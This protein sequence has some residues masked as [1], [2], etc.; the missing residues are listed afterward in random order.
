M[1]VDTFKHEIT[2]AVKAYDRYVICIDKVLAGFSYTIQETAGPAGYKLD[3]ST[4]SVSGTVGSCASR[5]TG[6]TPAK[7]PTTVTPDALFDNIPLTTF[8]GICTSQATGAAGP[9]TNCTV[10]CDFADGTSGAKPDVD[11][12]FA[13]QVPGTYHCTIVIDP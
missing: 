4:P 5:T 11:K 9:A 7:T 2:Q 1:T 3:T 10:T 6:A 8:E 12:I 13:D